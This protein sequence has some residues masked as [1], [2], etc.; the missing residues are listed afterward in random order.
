[1][2]ESFL[3]YGNIGLFFL[4]VVLAAVF[5]YHGLPKLRNSQAAAA[6]LGMSQGSVTVLGVIEVGSALALILGIYTQLAALLLA[7]VMVGAIYYK[8]QK[9]HI[10]FSAVDKVGWEFELTLLAAAVAIFLTGGG[11][12]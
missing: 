8:M 3:Q 1:M 2:F 5:I 9:W 12:L 6:G 4:Q 10:P 7:G 11:P